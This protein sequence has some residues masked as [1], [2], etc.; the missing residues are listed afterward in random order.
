MELMIDGWD[1]GAPIPAKY[2]FGQIPSEGRFEPG[3]NT[4]PGLSWTGV[5]TGTRSFALICH[6][7]DVPS[8]PDDVNQ[9]GRTVPA[10]LQRVDFFHWVVVNISTDRTQI[11]EG[12]ASSGVTPKGK[13]V[14]SR[15]YGDVGVNNYTDWFEGDADMGGTYADYDGPC[16]PW[17]DSIL[18]H[19]HFTVYALDVER[20]DMGPEFGGPEV[21]SAIEGHVLGSAA[22]MGTYTMNRDL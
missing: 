2:A 4:N 12:E 22:Y 5:P 1:D 14:G 21:L 6:D 9:E 7:P 16:P 18:H 8:K 20:L 15:P 10:D 11:A 13:P 3:G 19:Y 17:N